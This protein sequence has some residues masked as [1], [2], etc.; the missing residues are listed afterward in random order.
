MFNHMI[1]GSGILNG[2]YI[3]VT[4]DLRNDIKWDLRIELMEEIT[5][6]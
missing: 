2:T 5:K 3:E 4:T 1:K 6:Q